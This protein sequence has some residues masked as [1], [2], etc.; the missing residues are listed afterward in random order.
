MERRKVPTAYHR[1]IRLVDRLFGVVEKEH[2]LE[3]PK[4]TLIHWAANLTDE[5]LKLGV[6]CRLY[7]PDR[8]NVVVLRVV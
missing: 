4:H 7:S 6:E 1:L 3:V 5:N 8:R 2:L